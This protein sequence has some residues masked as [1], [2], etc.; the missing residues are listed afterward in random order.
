MSSK[1]YFSRIFQPMFGRKNVA[2]KPKYPGKK[3]LRCSFFPMWRKFA[4]TKATT[5]ILACQIEIFFGQI[6]PP[7]RLQ[8]RHFFPQIILIPLLVKP[9]INEGWWGSGYKWFRTLPLSRAAFVTENPATKM[10]LLER[11]PT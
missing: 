1:S 10:S 4:L 11:L 2:T 6:N 8:H 3:K 5:E 9:Q 7:S